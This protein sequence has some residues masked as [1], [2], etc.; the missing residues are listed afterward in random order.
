MNS[1]VSFS[2]YDV[3][4][5]V[6]DGIFCVSVDSTNNILHYAGSGNDWTA[7]DSGG[8]YHL[9]GVFGVGGTVYAMGDQGVLLKYSPWNKVAPTSIDTGYS[10]MN[11]IWGT[12]SNNVFAVGSNSRVYRYDGAT[13][14]NTSSGVVATYNGIW[15]SDSSNVFAVGDA[16]SIH[17]YNGTSWSRMHSFTTETLYAVWGNSA[18]DVYAVGGTFDFSDDLIT[19]IILHYDANIYDWWVGVYSS[20]IQFKDI[21]GTS[22]SNI[23]AVGCDG[24]LDYG[25][26]YHFDGSSWE[27]VAHLPTESGTTL[28]TALQSIWGIS[29]NDIFAGGLNGPMYHYDGSSWQPMGERH[30]IS[31]Q[32]PQ[33]NCTDIWGSSGTDVFCVGLGGDIYHYNGNPQGNWGLMQSYCESYLY[34]VW[35]SSGT[36]VFAVGEGST[37]LHF[38]G[39]CATPAI[40]VVPTSVDFGIVNLYTTNTPTTVTVNNT[41]GTTLF[42]D[43]INLYQDFSTEFNITNDNCTGSALE[44]GE[45]ATFQVTFSPFSVGSRTANLMIHSNDPYRTNT[46]IPLSGYGQQTSAQVATATGTGIATFST[47]S[48]S[49]IN[50]T[51]SATTSCGSL[52]GVTF[53]H[54]FFSFTITNITPGSTV[55]ITITFPSNVP[56][57]TQYWKCINGQWVD[58]TSLIGD[59]DGDNVL[60][61]T[62]TDGGLGDADGQVNGVITDP[63]GPAT[64]ISTPT[65][66]SSDSDS[67]SYLPERI[68][69]APARISVKY[70]TVQ[71]QQALAN[72]PITVYFNI[73][74]SGD[75]AGSYKATLKI[76]GQV[77]ETRTG[78]VG[79]HA[80]VPLKFEVLKDKP[81]TYS[82]DINGQQSSFT[83]LDDVGNKVKPTKDWAILGFIVCAMGVLVVSVL[84]IQRRR[85]EC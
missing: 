7:M 38:T 84:L 76:N 42:I 5:S 77:E 54:G 20:N 46:V 23:Y 11:G 45:S 12:G 80:A 82:L 2:L 13:W 53:P 78:R 15:G 26:I 68:V 58:V 79:S 24:N 36:N 48:G 4:G 43:S 17:R 47:S 22:P 35:G 14:S 62:I 67:S 41:G 55:T 70:L 63:G 39:P 51:A 9:R 31:G 50:L 30:P 6:G 85:S 37:I 69:S 25:V 81:G 40:N 75:E 1:G 34:G 64:R 66:V 29:A 32:Y 10:S 19:G 18:S 27:Q 72:Q 71:P 59:N 44:P 21:W 33:I 56:A 60:T 83:I 52:S 49:I 57:N 28:P 3:W 8:Y 16:G 73:A 65:T 74:N 61:L